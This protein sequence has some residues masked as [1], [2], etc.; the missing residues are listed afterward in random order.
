MRGGLAEMSESVD[1]VERGLAPRLLFHGLLLATAVG[2]FLGTSFA[3]P[4]VTHPACIEGG[5]YYGFPV[6]YWIRCRGPLMP[7]DG[8]PFD[9]PQLNAIAVVLDVALWY[10]V[11]WGGVGIARRLARPRFMRGS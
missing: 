11:L 6:A 4:S 1:R 3:F 10:V 7:G 8:Q 2:L 5:T 9:P